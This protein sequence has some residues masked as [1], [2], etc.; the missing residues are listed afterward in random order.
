MEIEEDFA[1]LRDIGCD[2]VQG[3]YFS[4]PKKADDIWNTL[5]HQQVDQVG[6]N[7]PLMNI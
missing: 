6:L 4:K 2:L 5:H 3:F 7:F 1:V